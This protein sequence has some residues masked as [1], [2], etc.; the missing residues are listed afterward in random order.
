MSFLVLI[1]W[2]KTGWTEAGRIATKER[3]KLGLLKLSE[4][5]GGQDLVQ[6][7]YIEGKPL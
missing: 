5:A 6:R 1:P 3:K 4:Q 7:K 2:P